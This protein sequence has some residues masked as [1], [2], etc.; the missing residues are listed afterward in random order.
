MKNWSHVGATPSSTFDVSDLDVED[1][2]EADPDQQR[3][4]REVDD[5]E[6]HVQVRRLLDAD[7]V[8]PDQEDDDDRADDDVPGVLA[9][10]LPEDRQVV[11]DEERRDRDRGDVDEHLRP[12]GAE[13]G[14]LVE[15]VAGEAR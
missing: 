14:E 7:D 5:G 10:G 1:E 11:R 3:L 6:E 15:R 2:E 8:D 9:Q 12:G 4:R 13:A